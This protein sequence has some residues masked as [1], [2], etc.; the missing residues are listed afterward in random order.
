MV[1]RQ[2]DWVYQGRNFK[3]RTTLLHTQSDGMVDRTSKRWSTKEKSLHRTR[4]IGRQDC[5]SSS[6]PKASIHDATGLTPAS[7]VFG[8]PTGTR[9]DVWSSH[10]QGTTQNRSRGKFSGPSTCHPQLLPTPEAGSD[11]MKVRAGHLRG[12]PR[13]RQSVALSPDPYEGQIAQAPILVG[14]PVQGSHSNK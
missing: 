1:G 13:R 3:T 11:Q 12:L 2:V 14:G 5:S 9:P 8:T 6:W 7:L 10:R 4:G